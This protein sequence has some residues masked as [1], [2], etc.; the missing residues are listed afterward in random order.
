[1]GTLGTDW[2]IKYYDGNKRANDGVSNGSNWVSVTSGSLTAK[3]GYIF[4]LKTGTPETELLI[5]LNTDI[6]NSESESTIPVMSYNSG[7]AAEVHKGWNLIGQPYLSR[8]AAQTGSD[9]PFMV[10]PNA[11]GKTYS[12]KSKAIGTLPEI[13]PLSAYFVQTAADGNVSFGL[14]GRQSARSMV[15]KNA[16]D[17]LQLKISNNNGIDDTYLI[18]DDNQSTAYQISQDMEKWLGT[19]SDKPQIYSA[20]ND[21]KYAFNALPANSVNNLEIGTYTKTSGSAT[22]SVDASQASGISSLML[23]DNSNGF[24]TDLLTSDYHFTT[25]EGIIDES[26]FTLTIQKISTETKAG[27]ETNE[28]FV[29]LNNGR[30]IINNMKDLKSVQVYDAAGH[31]LT[32]INAGQDTIELP[33]FVKGVYTIKIQ[34]NNKTLT[35][36]MII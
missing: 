27:F 8:F 12:V 33:T 24:V 22:I 10:V 19:G 20:L 7:I 32:T 11:D 3:K 23:N 17:Y 4:G 9:A 30:I 35:R 6:L 2:F 5:P 28:P 14:N 29:T 13:N 26:R 16:I 31:L 25:S 18:L 36:K 34:T 21:V 1:M 15:E